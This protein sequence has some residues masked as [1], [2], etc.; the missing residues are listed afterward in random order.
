[1]LFVASVKTKIKAENPTLG[2]KDHLSIW[3]SMWAIKTDDEKEVWRERFRK[4]QKS[5]LAARAEHLNAVLD[6]ENSDSESVQSK[7]TP[8]IETP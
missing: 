4:Q 6:S 8:N 3:A 7:A 1:M 2:S 5:A